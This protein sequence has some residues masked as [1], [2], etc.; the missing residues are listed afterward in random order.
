MKHERADQ[1]AGAVEDAP[2]E[3]RVAATKPVWMLISSLSAVILLAGGTWLRY[4]QAQQDVVAS[5]V[6]ELQ[7][8]EVNHGERLM[9]IET[10]MDQVE[11]NQEEAKTGQ[12]RIE[13]KIDTVLQNQTQRSGGGR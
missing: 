11:H 12:R 10:K 5:D 8:H 7:Q 3:I 2:E 6:H 1:E 9:R 13:D 4:V